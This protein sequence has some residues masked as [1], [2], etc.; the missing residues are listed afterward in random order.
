MD[1]VNDTPQSGRS[2]GTA[3]WKQHICAWQ[4]SGLNQSQYCHA[5]QIPVSSFSN[6]RKRL[7]SQP[8]EAP[9]ETNTPRFIEL[10]MTTDETPTNTDQQLV[11]EVGAARIIVDDNTNIT[12]FKK[13]IGCLEGIY[14]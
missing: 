9:V 13:I 6:W 10:P 7:N 4:S 8:D 14:D 1:N 12:L 2:K 11:V 3:F 5:N